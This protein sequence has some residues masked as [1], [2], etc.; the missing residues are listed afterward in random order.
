MRARGDG[1]FTPSTG[2]PRSTRQ[3]AAQ[4]ARGE[5]AQHRQG[6]FIRR[7][8]SPR[9]RAGTRFHISPAIQSRLELFN[10]HSVLITPQVRGLTPKNGFESGSGWLCS[11][12]YIQA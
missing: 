11:L 12:A 10:S 8:T 3:S 6:R 2:R 9:R 5:R 1:R 4:Y 7:G